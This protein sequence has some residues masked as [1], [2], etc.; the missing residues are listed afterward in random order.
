MRDS[1]EGEM[2]KGTDG[3]AGPG[4]LG[5]L[6]R[7]VRPYL[8]GCAALSI[9]S[10]AAGMGSYIAVAEIAR[11]VLGAGTDRVWTWVW[12]GAAGSAIWLLLF[13]Q[14]SRLGHF[15]DAAVLHHLRERIVNHLGTVPLGW[16]RSAGS[17]R[18]ERAMTGDLEEMHE[19][20]A[21]AL[22]QLVGAAI[23]AAVAAA[24]L[25]SVDLRL[26]AVVIAV[27]AATALSYRVSMRSMTGHM[28][29][30]VAA[31]RRMSTASIE[32]ADGIAVVKTFGTGG[33]VLRRFDDAVDEHTEAF[34]AWVREV[35][36]SSAATRVLGSEMAILIS[37]TTAG[38][39]LVAGGD[40]RIGDIAACLIV[41]VGMPTAIIPVVSAA[42]GVRKGRMGAADIERLLL[43]PALSEPAGSRMPATTDIQFDRVSFSYDGGSLA[44]DDVTATFAPGSLTAVVGPSGAGKSTLVALIPRFHDVTAG[45]IRI[46]GVDVRDMGS[47]ELLGSLSLVFQDVMLL[48]DTVAE[49]IRIGRPEATHAEVVAAARAAHV[50]DVIRQLP[51]GYDT[52][53]DATAG[54]LSGGERQRITIARAILSRARIVLLDEAT[55]ALDPDAEAAVQDALAELT[56]GRT[57]IVIAHR[58]HTVVDAD[59]I[60]V[61]DGG[62]LVEQGSHQVLLARGGRYARMWA[63][64]EGVPA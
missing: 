60:L 33:R 18:V 14:S 32:Y 29:R 36:Y 41:A 59:E 42:Q 45:A 64:Q 31:E 3:L 61:L 38:L 56:V 58:L 51:L 63:A 9:G 23:A 22:G 27:V 7:P 35:R 15:A 52:V 24:Y 30:L 53:L 20:I 34:A 13:V 37:V 28:N 4:A 44:L 46:G 57:V 47:R 21:H 50:H 25:V 48:N 1:S 8:I 2:P 43:E 40:I 6:L 10:A 55:A 11:E 26:T 49:N 16:F 54:A 39:F 5:R 62:R 19:V 17:G 12:V